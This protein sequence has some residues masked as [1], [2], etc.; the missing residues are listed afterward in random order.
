MSGHAILDRVMKNQELIATFIAV[1]IAIILFLAGI[2]FSFEPYS[3]S[4]TAPVVPVEPELSRGACDDVD[5]SEYEACC[6]SWAE[7]NQ[8]FVPLCI[9]EW[10]RS[11]DNACSWICS[12]SDIE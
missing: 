3:E 9:G 7:E 5:A 1:F 8:V 6:D 11:T 4:E 12:T 10:R 2:I